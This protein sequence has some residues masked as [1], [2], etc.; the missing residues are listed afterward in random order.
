MSE[1]T[2]NADGRP[3]AAADVTDVADTTGTEHNDTTA[4]LDVSPAEAT[5]K[6]DATSPD[7]PPTA[8]L[9]L[10]ASDSPDP[11][12]TWQLPAGKPPESPGP[13]PPH[14]LPPLTP[15]RDVWSAPRKHTDAQDNGVTSGSA[16]GAPRG[17]RAGTLVWG[18]I[19]LV[20]GGLL[21]AVAVGVQVDPVTAVIVLLAGIGVALLVTAL[22]PHRRADGQ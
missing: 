9:P 8:P 15:E 17:V 10:G 6:L 7:A 21:L 20:L 4:V 12:T 3:A 16:P 22:L 14:D 13:Q 11:A 18:L 2:S 5:R 1:N 19:L